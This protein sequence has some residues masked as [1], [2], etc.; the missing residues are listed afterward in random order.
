MYPYRNDAHTAGRGITE[1]LDIGQRLIGR[2]LRRS[3]SLLES[4]HVTQTEVE[5]VSINLRG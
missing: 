4:K 5:K 3:K 1:P 2:Q